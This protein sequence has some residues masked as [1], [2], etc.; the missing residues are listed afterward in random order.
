MEQ[1]QCDFFLS[2][3]INRLKHFANIAYW[4]SPQQSSGET[5]PGKPG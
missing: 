2:N 1:R 3:F 4:N 5:N